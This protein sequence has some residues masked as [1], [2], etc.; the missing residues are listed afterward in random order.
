MKATRAAQTDDGAAEQD[1]SL[2][3]PQ[4]P[5]R[6][7]AMRSSIALA[8]SIALSICAYAPAGDAAPLRTLPDLQ[9]VKIYEITFGTVATTYTPDAVQIT[10]RL[11]DPL[12][13]ANRDFSVFTNEY[14][15]F[16]YS[17]ADGT[18]NPDGAFITIEGVWYSE[19]ITNGGMNIN[20]VELVFAGPVSVFGDFVASFVYGSFCDVD[21]GPVHC[22]P[23]SE[24]L[25]VDHDLSTFPRF[26]LTS[27]ANP[28]ERFRLTVGFDAYSREDADG[29]GL[30]DD[31]DNCTLVENALQQDN[32]G[33]GIGD[34]CDADFNDDCIVNFVDLGTMRGL[35]FQPGDLETD[36]NN[37]DS[38]NFEDVG[39][40]KS[41]FFLPPGPSGVPN[42]CSP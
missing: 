32:D 36:M 10:T 20:E 23:G 22:N 17:D 6:G 11:P 15:D 27:G 5:Q 9:S 31:E 30:F 14:Y 26:G 2:R 25:A 41:G 21:L 19:T 24:A 42:V 38:T 12:T 18:P 8:S 7:A 1:H 16:F 28:S 39:L 13:G 35:F 33:D 29:D 37:D 3:P 34:I 40:L 4:H